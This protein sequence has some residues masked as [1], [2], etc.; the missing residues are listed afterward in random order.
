MPRAGFWKASLRQW[1]NDARHVDVQDRAFM[2]AVKPLSSH[3]PLGLRMTLIP[4]ASPK[5][6]HKHQSTI[7][8]SSCEDVPTLAKILKETDTWQ[9]AIIID[10]RLS[11]V[12]S[13]RWQPFPRLY[14]DQGAFYSRA[15]NWNDGR[16][17]FWHRC[18]QATMLKL[19]SPEPLCSETNLQAFESNEKWQKSH[20]KFKAR[21]F[22]LSVLYQ[23]LASSDTFGSFLCERWEK[24]K[25]T[26]AI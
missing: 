11:G 9:Y 14:S 2:S 19:T 23:K 13:E 26:Y 7:R 18:L 17:G 12:I 4:S 8:S 24:K 22:Q 5:S 6:S 25:K 21:S 15:W 16:D 20:F 3:L 1:Q 10:L